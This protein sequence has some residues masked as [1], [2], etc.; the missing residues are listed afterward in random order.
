MAI[1]QVALAAMA[2][3]AA[4]AANAQSSSV[5]LYGVVDAFFQYADANDSVTRLQSGGLNGSRLGFRG[6]EDL[7]GGLRAIFAI[8][9]GI[10]LDDGTVG[11]NKTMWGRQAWVGLG[12]DFGQVTLG[13]QY[14][15]LYFVSGDFSAFTNGAYGASTGVIGGF[16]EYEPV[17]DLSRVNNSVKYE[18]PSLGGLKIG[19]MWGFGEVA[20]STT[21]TRIAD[22][23]ARYTAGP[24]DALVSFI[25]DRVEATDK[26]ERTISV[27]GAYNFGDF[28]LLA[29]YI[30]VNDRSSAN[31]DGDG[32]WIGGDYRFGANLLRLQYVANKPDADDSDT[33]ALGIGYQYDLS[34]RTAL[35]TSLTHFKNDGATRWHSKLPEDKSFSSAGG[36]NVNEFVV[37]VRHSF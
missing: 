14:S 28:R 32:F 33:Q 21:D 3:A 13:R 22:I 4:A 9:S 5:T 25:D 2:M 17:R 35:Y 36:D 7:G 20:D 26:E 24:I 11:Q 6:T 8:E 1:K 29:G 19:A 16:G 30:N 27:G 34:K 23:Y 12:G 31:D 10:Q 18:T 37:G 15:S